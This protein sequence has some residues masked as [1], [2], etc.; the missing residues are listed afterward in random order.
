MSQKWPLLELLSIF[1]TIVGRNL[2]YNDAKQTI[3]SENYLNAADKT[4][5]R[6]KRESRNSGK[7][8]FPYGA[9]VAYEAMGLFSEQIVNRYCDKMSS[10]G[11]QASKDQ[12]HEDTE[13]ICELYRW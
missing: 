11:P 2:N 10:K 7:P 3:Q 12:I 9:D 1:Q 4:I 6:K 8:G 13:N 5:I